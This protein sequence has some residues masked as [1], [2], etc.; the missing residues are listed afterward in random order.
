MEADDSS[1]AHCRKAM[2]PPKAMDFAF[3][4]S[5][6]SGPSLGAQVL[7]LFLLH[8]L[9]KIAVHK[10]SERLEVPDILLPDIREQPRF[11]PVCID[12]FR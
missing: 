7:A 5:E 3:P 4:Q 12:F 11:E 9:G 1:G 6:T 8:F 10:M 2:T